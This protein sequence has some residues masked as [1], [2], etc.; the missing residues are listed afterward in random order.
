MLQN[1]AFANFK[2]WADDTAV[3]LGRITGLFGANSSGKSSGLQ[4]L[5]VLKQTGESLDR[6]RVLHL[7]DDRSPVDLGTF[8]DVV[9]RHDTTRP[10]R[11][12]LDWSVPESIEVRDPARK[13]FVV[14]RGNDLSF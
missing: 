13:D 2:S 9:Y 5:L 10:L 11:F 3:P 4:A 7:G 6:T 12:A 1:L 14:L 8:Y